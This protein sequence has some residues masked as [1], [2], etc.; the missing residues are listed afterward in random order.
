MLKIYWKFINMA[1]DTSRVAKGI[2]SLQI[3]V[4]HNDGAH[5]VIKDP[6]RSKHGYSWVGGYFFPSGDLRKSAIDIA[7]RET[8]VIIEP[9]SV[10]LRQIVYSQTRINGHWIANHCMSA[11]ARPVS[12]WDS[13]A[14]GY[15]TF[16]VSTSS[17]RKQV[18]KII[19]T[20]HGKPNERFEWSI[21]DG[22][23]IGWHVYNQ[24][25][26]EKQRRTYFSPIPIVEVKTEYS[27]EQRE[28]F[29]WGMNVGQIVLQHTYRG[30][31]GL[32]LIENHD[33]PGKLAFAGGKV[34]ALDSVSS[35]NIDVASCIVAEGEEEIGVSL[36][37]T[38]IVGCALTPFRAIIPGFVYE[39]EG[40]NSIVTTSITARAVDPRKLDEAINN[41]RGF[42][43]EKYKIKNISFW[44]RDDLGD[45]ARKGEMRT[46]D[47]S[48]LLSQW[49]YGT[50]AER[51]NLEQIAVLI[52]DR[53]IPFVNLTETLCT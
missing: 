39:T 2:V 51:P 36:R 7:K 18:P 40:M 41:P 33:N 3:E 38:S 6:G 11:R 53:H 50:P 26:L 28:G 20:I 29:G 45:L 9:N 42:I 43:K 25:S 15:E 4:P 34:E 31:E 8:G 24:F 1:L 48:V 49:L 52:P 16:L 30:K 23:F 37:P 35:R 47:M 32:V 10:H 21:S 44:P 5:L 22:G 12:E 17:L 27:S 14:E 13:P 19:E 46:P